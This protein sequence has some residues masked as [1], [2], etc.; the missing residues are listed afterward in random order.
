[1][2]PIVNEEGVFI[3]MMGEAMTNYL[4]V[5]KKI[6][7]KH[8]DTLKRLNYLRDFQ[9]CLETGKSFNVQTDINE[10]PVRILKLLPVLLWRKVT[11]PPILY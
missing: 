7:G 4:D 10:K 1:M 8:L 11:S 9:E 5:N 6:V 2:L 3:K